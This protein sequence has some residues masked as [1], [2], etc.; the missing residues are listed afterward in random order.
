MFPI[1]GDKVQEGTVWRA[2]SGTGNRGLDAP[3][4]REKFQGWDSTRRKRR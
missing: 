2:A 1:A 3:R 4:E